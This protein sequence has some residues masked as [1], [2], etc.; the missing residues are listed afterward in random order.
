MEASAACRCRDR[1]NRG[2]RKK[3]QPIKAPR[4]A[5]SGSQRRAAKVSLMSDVKIPA[6][7]KINLRLEILGK[8]PDGY[9]E[10]RTI[11]QTVSLHDD[12]KLK[13][14]RKPGIALRVEGHSALSGEP[15]H[16]NLV[17]RAVQ[18]LQAEVKHEG[19]GEMELKRR[20]QAG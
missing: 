1:E 16:K 10:L 13:R 3:I 2:S 15:A 5:E 19:G 17:S 7:A 12:L 11:F 4:S 14:A 6:F 18:A 20:I 9:H 8:R